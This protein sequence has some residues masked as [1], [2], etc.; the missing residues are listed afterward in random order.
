ML[1]SKNKDNIDLLKRWINIEC[2]IRQSGFLP[3]NE[4]LTKQKN[5]IKEINDYFIN[6]NHIPIP[7]TFWKGLDK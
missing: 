6:E 7:E 1:I 4:D 2:R 3:N 5:A